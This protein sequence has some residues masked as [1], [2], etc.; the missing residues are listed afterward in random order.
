MTN[1]DGFLKKENVMTKADNNQLG[2][3]SMTEDSQY[4]SQGEMIGLKIEY[5][6]IIQIFHTIILKLNQDDQL[7]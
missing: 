2:N 3:T 1:I 5:P 6:W 7:K 4:F